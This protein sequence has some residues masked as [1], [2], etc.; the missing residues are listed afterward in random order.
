MEELTLILGAILAFCITFYVFAAY[1]RPYARLKE[2]QGA[3]R[4]LIVTSHP[5]DETMFFGPTILSL[6]GAKRTSTQPQVAANNVFLLC[7][8]N[9]DYKNQGKVRKHELYR[10]CKILGIPEEN[11]TVL[12]YTRLRD[13]PSVRW[14]EEVVS[15]V[16][17]QTVHSHEIDT[18]LTFD[19]Y[20]VSGHKNH[21]SVY[22][23]MAYLHMEH[24][25]PETCR[26][27]TLR[28]V[29]ILRKY[30]SI[31]D[32]PMSFMLAPHAYT[33]SASDWL[34]LHK[35]MAMHRSQFVW[36]RKLY[37]FFSRYNFINT[38]DSMKSYPKMANKTSRSSL[39]S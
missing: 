6:C 15:E 16:V 11:L 14:R 7:L 26:V 18:I 31:L 25:L 28:S 34:K 36:F 9:G 24:K 4:V 3:K 23:A 35:A 5:D 12:S 29:N 2:I 8:S 32:V 20:G 30:S 13:D 21:S 10:A 37:M 33:A 27:F 17:L 38:F 39:M 22:S 1:V 19:R